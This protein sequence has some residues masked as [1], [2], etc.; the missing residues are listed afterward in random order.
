MLRLYLLPGRR[1]GA[2]MIDAIVGVSSSPAV[3]RLKGGGM[4]P[5][6][7]VRLTFEPGLI[8]RGAAYLFASVIDRFLGLYATINSFTRLTATMR[9]QAEPVAAFPARLA[10]RPLL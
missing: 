8:D 4:V 9:G 3:S 1:E 6:T 7:D 2:L 10:E 5:G